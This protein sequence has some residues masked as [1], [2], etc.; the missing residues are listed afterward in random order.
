M[1]TMSMVVMPMMMMVVVVSLLMLGLR[2]SI[3]AWGDSPFAT[4]PEIT[5]DETFSFHIAVSGILRDKTKD[6]KLIN[7][8]FY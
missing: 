7:K 6:I 5:L 2:C 3:Q 1:V 8:L 4:G